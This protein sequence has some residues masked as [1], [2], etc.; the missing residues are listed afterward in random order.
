MDGSHMRIFTGVSLA[1]I[2]HF[3]ENC[4]ILFC[5]K[6]DTVIFRIIIGIVSVRAAFDIGHSP[7]RFQCENFPWKFGALH[8]LNTD[9]DGSRIAEND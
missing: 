7:W 4:S 9:A 5:Q 2:E 6:A 1:H 8:F 3:R